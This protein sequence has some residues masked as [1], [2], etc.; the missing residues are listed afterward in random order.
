M[1]R[2]ILPLMLLAAL[3][4][5]ATPVNE[6]GKPPALS[7]VGSGIGETTGSIPQYPSPPSSRPGK[8]SLWNDNQ[9]RLF[10]DLR[11]LRP[12]D[13]LT[14]E[15]SIDDRARFENESERNRSTTRDLGFDLGFEWEGAETEGSGNASIDANTEASGAGTTERSERLQLQVAAVVVEV[16]ANGNLVIQGSQEVRVNAELRILTIGGIVRPA[17]ISPKNTIPYERIAEARVSYGGRGRL[18]EVQQ[19]PWGTQVLDNISPF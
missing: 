13:L 14:V 11:A 2:R 9:S 12:G 6:I 5:C 3:Y 19:P 16:L 15:I 4:G 17:D 7:E 8:F 1:T 10:T 18:T